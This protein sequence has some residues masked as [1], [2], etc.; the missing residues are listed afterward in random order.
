MKHRLG[1]ILYLT[2]WVL[3]AQPADTLSVVRIEPGI[4]GNTYYL[5][6]H[7]DSL[8]GGGNATLSGLLRNTPSIDIRGGGAGVGFGDLSIRGG[9]FN[10]AA[11]FINGIPTGNPQTGHHLLQLPIDP[12]SL[13][14]VQVI[15]GSIGFAGFGNTYAGAVNLI[16][17]TG[18]PSDLLLE[19]GQYGLFHS[20][21]NLR[22]TQGRN[23]HFLLSHYFTRSTGYLTRDDVN[24][25]DLL[26]YGQFGVY[27]NRPDARIRLLIQGGWQQ[28]KFG[29][30]R[31]YSPY[32]PWQYERL[33]NVHAGLRMTTGNRWKTGLMLAANLLKDRF[34]LF[35]EDRFTYRN[36]YY[37][38]NADT[39]AYAPGVYYRGANIH[40]SGDFS[41]ALFA[42]GSIQKAGKPLLGIRIQAKRRFQNIYGN[43][44]GTPGRD[45][46]YLPAERL[47]LNR[48]AVR[49]TDLWTVGL[50]ELFWQDGHIETAFSLLR[51]GNH[52][53]P[54]GGI[55]LQKK[56]GTSGHALVLRAGSGF[57][58][59]TFT[60]LFYNGPT[61]RGNPGLQPERN[62]ELESGIISH[63]H[64]INWKV[65]VFYRYE[66]ASIDWI[67]YPT[68]SH[69]HAENLCNRAMAG[70]R[71]EI[72]Y[73][74][75]SPWLRKVELSYQYLSDNRPSVHFDSKYALD[76]LRHYAILILTQQP[77]KKLSFRWT[78]RFKSRHGDYA[79]SGPGGLVFKP[80]KAFVLLDFDAR[81]R[82]TKKLNLFVHG[83][84]LLN[85]HAYDLAF[86]PMPGRWISAGVRS[87]F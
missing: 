4:T 56:L 12:S 54:L 7:P 70:L 21:V 82:I 43:K 63:W 15:D 64:T 83:F 35:R 26:T 74:L 40:H 11:V 31:L 78:A 39:A 9:T 10:Q 44:L 48:S 25:T 34:E 32:F 33:R 36:G 5:S 60:E 62:W 6:L 58:L 28:K 73:R 67:R 87:F 14:S 19:A 2:A 51:Y 20:A 66:I 76:Y 27:R 59:P 13:Q 81:F 30:N 52:Y 69:W 79:V 29:A 49:I 55:R 61:N 85:V 18:G 47:W 75:D 16:S 45:S 23:G 57:R 24:N 86:V 68:D 41:A 53:Y 72:A 77:L 80:Y 8:A 3:G 84:N 42:R 50:K 1:F 38:H 17:K 65:H 22:T 37:I 46:I 71:A